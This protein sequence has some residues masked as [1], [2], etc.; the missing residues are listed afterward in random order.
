VK[1]ND[2]FKDCDSGLSITQSLHCTSSIILGVFKIHNIAEAGFGAI[3][4]YECDEDH[5]LFGP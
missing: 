3:I 4:M 2:P 1:T 5:I